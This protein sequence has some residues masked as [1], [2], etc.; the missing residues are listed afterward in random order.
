MWERRGVRKRRRSRLQSTRVRSGEG[1]RGE[2]ERVE[3]MRRKNTGEP[4]L[5]DIHTT[6]IPLP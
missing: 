3:R 5:Q 6:P 1:I 2:E 4:L